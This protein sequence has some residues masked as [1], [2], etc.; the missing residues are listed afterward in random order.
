MTKV[1]KQKDIQKIFEIFEK[2]NPDPKTELNY[3]D[4]F[5]LLIAVL[6]SA[7]TT[8]VNVNKATDILFKV[9]QSPQEILDLGIDKLEEI[10]KTIGLYKTKAKH[11]MQLCFMLLSKHQ[12]IVP[13]TREELEAFPGV[14]RKTANVV[15]NEA[16]GQPT[17]AVDTHIFRVPQRI[18]LAKGKTPLEIEMQLLECVPSQF[19]KKA[20]HWLILHGRYICKARKP[21][22]EKCSISMLCQYGKNVDKK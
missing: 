21:E 20:H 18:G 9:A 2:E 10:I 15:L 12:G 7:Q 17:I 22:C 16:F 14:G 13:Q 4:P 5:T 19:L 6:L 8:D 11:V 1:L 3:H